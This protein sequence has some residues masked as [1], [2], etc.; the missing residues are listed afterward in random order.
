MTTFALV[1][2]VGGGRLHHGQPVPGAAAVLQQ[3][4]PAQHALP[5][6]GKQP[7]L[8]KEHVKRS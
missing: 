4:E 8:R 1:F 5:V 3:G 7:V 6:C 2:I